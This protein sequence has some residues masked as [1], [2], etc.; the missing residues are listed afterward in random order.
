MLA[1]R[2]RMVLAPLSPVSRRAAAL[3][4]ADTYSGAGDWLDLSGNG[5][6]A[7]MTDA[8]KHLP[9]TGQLHL[10]FPGSVGNNLSTPKPA[11]LLGGGTVEWQVTFTDGTTATGTTA[12]D[13]VL[14]GE[15]AISDKKVRAV[16][17][18]DGVGGAVVATLDLT[19]RAT[20]TEPYATVVQGGRT[21]TLNRTATGRKLAVVDRTMLLFGA[22]NRLT[23]ADS[24]LLDF[25]VNDPLTVS[26]GLRMYAAQ[27]ANA[28]LVAKKATVSSA[29]VGWVMYA[30]VGETVTGRS[31]DG[32]AERVSSAGAQ[33]A[34]RAC[35]LHYWRDRNAGRWFI[36]RDATQTDSDA[37]I[38]AATI[39]NAT[40][41]T[42]A[43]LNG[44]RADFEL[45]WLAIHRE[46]LSQ[47]EQLRL[48][49]EMGAPL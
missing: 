47:A 30:G 41:V 6:H 40:A 24:D 10:W 43:N 16:E 48:R 14:V 12:A 11:G 31:S 46:A 23:V 37:D 5:L 27:V 28:G 18:H 33:T 39:A 1:T 25:G 17:L 36:G 29:T 13:P 3:Y 21:W 42:I 7:V 9:F 34:G 2:R 35:S 32:T 15:A 8:P 26:L 49:R 20:V 22:P 45:Y 19:D 38:I 44:V 4:R